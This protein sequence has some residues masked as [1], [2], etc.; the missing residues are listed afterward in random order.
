MLIIKGSL[1]LLHSTH[2]RDRDKM[3]L[4]A[5]LCGGVWNGFLLGKAK[6]E[7]VPCRFC[8]KRD[9]DGHLFWECSFPPLQHVRDLPEFSFLMSLDRSKW[10]RCLLWHGWLP[11]LNGMPGGKPWASSFGELAAF[12]LEGCLGAYP[13]DFNAAWTPPDYWDADDIALEVPDHPNIWTDGSREDFSS[14]GGFEVAGAGFFLPASELAFDNVVWGTVEEYGNAQLERCRA[15]LPIPGVLQSVQRAEFWSATVA[16]QAYWPCHLGIDNL[17]VVRSI[18]RLLDAGCLAKPLPLVKDGDLVALV[19]HMI[20]TRGRSTVRVTKVKGHAKDYDVQHGR[21]RLVDQQGNVEADIAADLGRRHQTEVL[22]DARRRLLQ[23]R[24]Y[25]YPVMTD[26]HRFMIAIA[27]VS[28]NHDGKGGTAPDPLVWDQGSKPKFRKLDIRVTE[29]LA[30]L[31]GPPGFLHCD[32]VQVHAG[33]I[34]D[35]DV[36]AWPYSVGILVR[37]TS[38]LGTLH[39]PSGSV[40]FRHFGISFLELLILFEQWAGHRLLSESVTRPH[41]RAGRPILLPSVPVSEGIEIRHGCQFL[42]SLVRA[43]GK[44]PGGLAR[45]LPC[46]VGS[47]LSRLRHLGW[48]QC[49]HG[50]TSGPIESCHHLC[51]SAICGVLGYPRGSAAELLDGVL[52][53]R[54]CTTPFS[55]RFPTWSLPP[56]GHGRIRSLDVA[57]GHAVG[58]NTVKRV[59]LTRKTQGSV[60]PVNNPDQGHS[61]PRRWKRLR[62]PS[63]EGVGG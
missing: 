9:G 63:S 51:L 40:D 1:Q 5:I 38:F 22:I 18:G 4:R 25:W 43:L 60:T 42:S 39:W 61:T 55:K 7:D 45:F 35:A 54:C 33:H 8:G 10:P 62:P 3:L 50:L 17:N 16:L 2:L 30:S 29:D 11:G 20:R 48:N 53:L 19:H 37:F 34:T 23:A 27:R 21:V 13:V 32:W 41:V 56:V 24:S 49:S 14:I 12:H 26:L 52:K 59:R 57:T 46:Q 31:P 58:G 44:L 6:K 47:H 28:V 36:A 15:F